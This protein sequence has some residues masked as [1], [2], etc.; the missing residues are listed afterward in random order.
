MVWLNSFGWFDDDDDDVVG[1]TPAVSWGEDS[2]AQKI[3]DAM[4]EVIKYFDRVDYTTADTENGDFAGT[5]K[6]AADVAAAVDFFE[7]KIVRIVLYGAAAVIGF[8]MLQAFT[9]EKAR[10][11]AA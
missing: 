5:S 7:G 3:A 10:I 1:D 4:P 2:D 6:A 9:T 11:A 8:G